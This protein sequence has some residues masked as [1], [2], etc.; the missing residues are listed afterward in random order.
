[1]TETYKPSLTAEQRT[2]WA[3]SFTRL[4]FE[5][6]GKIVVNIRAGQGMAY[7]VKPELYFYNAET[8]R[9]ESSNLSFW[10]AACLEKSV[11]KEWY[12]DWI[13]FSGIGYD[14]AH[15]MA[16]TIGTLLEKYAPDLF[17]EHLPRALDL[18]TSRYFEGN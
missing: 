8:K 11:R 18:A 14:R 1:M 16:Y 2:Y 12:G 13:R 7:Q 3:E 17:H 9:V 6:G 4:I 5:R 15:D 10:V